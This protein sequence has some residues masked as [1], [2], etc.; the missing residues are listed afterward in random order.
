MSID[1]IKSPLGPIEITFSA[2]GIQTLAFNPTQP[3]PIEK[4][5]AW[6]ESWFGQ[7]TAYLLGE[8]PWPVLPVD[9][10]IG[11]PFQ[12]IV[13]QTLQKIPSGHIRTYS[14][15]AVQIGRPKAIRAVATACAK[16]PI[17]LL[18]PC[19]RVIGKN[20]KLTGY[21]WGLDRKKALLEL[22]KNGL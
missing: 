7:I 11:T 19:H 18:V 17:A 16:N 13:W 1:Y 5:P 12:N 15:I 21:Y 8:G 4:R 9:I 22:E 2:I 20:G 6:A 14:D 10:Q 3:E